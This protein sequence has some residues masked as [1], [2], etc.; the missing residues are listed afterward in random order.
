M[1]IGRGLFF[2][3]FLIEK[4][5]IIGVSILF[6]TIAA[7][8]IGYVL[9]LN[10]ISFW[11]ASVI[12]NLA[13]E[14]PYLGKHLIKFIW[15]S[16]SVDQPTVNRFFIFHFILPFI[17]LAFVIL[18]ITILH[19]T[20][21]SNP[22]G[23]SSKKIKIKFANNFSLN[24]LITVSL[25]ITLFIMLC[26]L[27]P[28]LLGDDENFIIANPAST[29]KHIQPEWYFLLAYRILRSIPNKLG[30]VIAL[31]IRIAILYIT[32]F[33]QISKNKNIS[34]YPINK[35]IFWFFVL[36]AILLTWIGAQRIE[37]PFIL[38]GQTGAIFYFS[39]FIIHPIIIKYWDFIINK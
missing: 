14:I 5:W 30:G 27:K 22:I 31:V 10:Q 17:I 15:G 19:T 35:L 24:D 21:S 39:Y 36:N 12:T 16:P 23:M 2:H 13:T 6:L 26:I 37:Q 11:G 4:T 29:P 38:I 7:A 20:G 18:H 9:P 1:H 8:F 3:S 33:T 28:L 32:P 34:Y 25:F